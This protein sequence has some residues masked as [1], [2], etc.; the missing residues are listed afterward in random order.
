LNTTTYHAEED[1][2]RVTIQTGRE[3]TPKRECTLQLCIRYVSKAERHLQ[4]P[5]AI[6]FRGKGK[7]ISK[8][9]R[10]AWDKRVHV[11]HQLKAW[12][13]GVVGD[14][15]TVRTFAPCTSYHQNKRNLA[16]VEESV[17][18]TDNLK[19]QTK[20]EWRRLLWKVART[21]SHLF[22]TGVTDELQ[23]ID[24]CIGN[25]VKTHMGRSHTE[26][27]AETDANGRSN[28]ERMLAREVTASERRILLT[29]WL[30]DAWD[31]VMENFDV[32]HSG[33]KNGCC[34][35]QNG[36]G[37]DKIRLQGLTE[38]YTFGPEDDDGPEAGLRFEV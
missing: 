21:K 20:K 1:G 34:L 4:P 2:P 25:M 9:E 10:A 15:W 5:A 32:L 33:D 14:E 29:R 37:R 38:A 23:T 17:I 6:I 35:G 22:P 19:T 7:R 12:Y 26:W 3:G 13:D 31:H 24:D 16:E 28:L 27:L 11:Y 8:E 30:G 18:F 36:E